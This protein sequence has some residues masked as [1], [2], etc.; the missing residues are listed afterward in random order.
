VKEKSAMPIMHLLDESMI[1]W[2]TL[3]SW[4]WFHL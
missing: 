4:N 1:W 2:W 3:S